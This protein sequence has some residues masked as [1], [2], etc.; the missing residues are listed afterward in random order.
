MIDNFFIRST[1][2]EKLHDAIYAIQQRYGITDGDITPST[3]YEYDKAEEKVIENVTTIINQQIH[4]QA[5]LSLN[6][7][8]SEANWQ[9]VLSTLEFTEQKN[10]NGY[11]CYDVYD[12]N[13]LPLWQY[14]GK[15]EQE[16]LYHF[17]C[18]MAL[19]KTRGEIKNET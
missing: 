5:E 16:K 3:F 13:G 4:A 12:D 6:L 18:G 11:D 17:F 7:N 10:P 19:M 2:Q 15:T 14:T 9:A 1:V 8:F